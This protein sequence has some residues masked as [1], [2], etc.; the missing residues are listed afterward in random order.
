MA[1]KDQLTQSVG[2]HTL[3]G[4]HPKLPFRRPSLLNVKS[5]S[6]RR[7]S[8]SNDEL[9]PR[10]PNLPPRQPSPLCFPYTPEPEPAP[11]LGFSIIKSN[12]YPLPDLKKLPPGPGPTKSASTPTR[13]SAD[14]NQILSST[15]D[16]RTAKDKD[17]LQITI[18]DLLANAKQSTDFESK[19]LGRSAP[20]IFVGSS[21]NLL[22]LVGSAGSAASSP[23][24][25]V[26]ISPALSASIASVVSLSIS[27]DRLDGP[28][29]SLSLAAPPAPS[30]DDEPEMELETTNIDRITQ[31][32]AKMFNARCLLSVIE[33]HRAWFKSIVCWSD[34]TELD[35]DESFCS[36]DLFKGDE[37]LVV[38]DTREDPRFSSSP[39]V[40]GRRSIRY[41]AGTPLRCADGFMLGTLCIID[42]KPRHFTDEQLSCLQDIACLI[43]QE[44]EQRLM[45]QLMLGISTVGGM[46]QDSTLDPFVAVDNALQVVFTTLGLKSL[47]LIVAEN[48]AQP[49]KL[50]LLL[51]PGD[52]PMKRASPEQ[53]TIVAGSQ[54]PVFFSRT[55]EV[56][57]FG[58]EGPPSAGGSLMV[59]SPMVGLPLLVTDV[60]LYGVAFLYN[61]IER[62]YTASDVDFMKSIVWSIASFLQRKKAEQASEDILVNILP[63][64]IVQQLK[65]S[66]K[67]VA[68]RIPDATIL[69]ADFVGFT[70][71]ASRMK[72]DDVVATLFRIFSIFDQ[73]TEHR[74]VEKVKTIG[75]GYMACANIAF[76]NNSHAESCVELALDMMSIAAKLSARPGN[77]LT[78]FRI[79][80]NS[81]PVVAGVLNLQR[82]AFDVFGDTVNIASRMEST[83]EPG[84]VRVSPAT[85]MQLDHTRYVWEQQ[86]V[87]VKGKGMMPTY[88][89]RGRAAGM[90]REDSFENSL[91]Q[92]TSPLITR[93]SE[94]MGSLRRSGTDP[95]SSQSQPS[96]RVVP[97]TPDR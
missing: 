27:T 86:D 53:M 40:L 65:M 44:L 91:L 76:P 6:R 43:I 18:D 83:S 46:F 90:P 49:S 80:I 1:S 75:D 69:F 7:R 72:P 36:P 74:K 4:R 41:Y 78:Q 22:S 61:P 52:L 20:S 28:I 39:L 42:N 71:L 29:S 9:E 17:S 26:P 12:S 73:L 35:H 33:E 24:M 38:P 94:P 64:P 67:S 50:A 66:R 55:D 11:K 77:E 92:S 85:W 5:E 57:C 3:P 14:R 51:G 25:P 82:L 21:S 15:P 23:Q 88:L 13:G 81:G 16:L 31:M 2:S 70:T 96:V 58:G 60:E 84:C 95:E 45:A 47:E 10:L 37:V 34:R 48:G 63:G 56:V 54:S 97:P 93:H 68:H 87:H 89:I 8:V 62:P 79:G 19:R 32:A 30:M 59:R